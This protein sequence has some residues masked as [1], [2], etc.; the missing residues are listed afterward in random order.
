MMLVNMQKRSF[1]QVIIE[2]NH[3]STSSGC[4]DLYLNE[5]RLNQG[6][7]GTKDRF[8]TDSFQYQAEK[9]NPEDNTLKVVLGEKSPGTYWLS[10]VNVYVKRIPDKTGKCGPVDKATQDRKV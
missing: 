6:I 7:I 1:S 4:V 3:R 10:D 5:V 2:L 9:F 8:E